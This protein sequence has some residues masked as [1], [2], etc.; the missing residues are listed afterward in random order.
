MTVGE[1]IKNERL[2]QGLS[3]EELAKK[4]G[5]SDKTAISKLE[6][7]DN[8]ITLK[9]V[10]RIA[11]A[12]GVDASFLMGWSASPMQKQNNIFD[13]IG[14]KESADKVREERFDFLFETE[15]KTTSRS[16]TKEEAIIIEGYRELSVDQK[17]LMKRM[18]NYY[19]RLANY[20]KSVHRP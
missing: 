13:L 12:L 6:H 19:E 11:M 7:A 9:Q 10:K 5:Y 15:Y 20:D 4:A 3:Q 14:D 17:E 2:A 16:L 1:R 8:K 18:V